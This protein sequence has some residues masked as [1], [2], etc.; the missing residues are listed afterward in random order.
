LDV[1]PNESVR[2]PYIDRGVTFTDHMSYFE[3]LRV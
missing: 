3:E 1:S 2:R